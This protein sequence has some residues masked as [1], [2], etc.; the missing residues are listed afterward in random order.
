MSQK[1]LIYSCIFGSRDFIDVF[2][3]LLESMD[4]YGEVTDDVEYMI[5]THPDLE[6]DV[7]VCLKGYNR[8]KHTIKTVDIQHEKDATCCRFK[9][10]DLIKPDEFQ[11]ILYI[12]IDVLITNKLDNILSIDTQNKLCALREGPHRKRHALLFDDVT[13]EELKD[14]RGTFNAGVLLFEPCTKIRK[15]FDSTVDLLNK[16]FTQSGINQSLYSL[17]EDPPAPTHEMVGDF[18]KYHDDGVMF[19]EVNDQNYLNYTAIKTNMY[20]HKLW[21]TVVLNPKTHK[22]FKGHVISHFAGNYG[23]AEKKE[24]K[25]KEYLEFLKNEN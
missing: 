4:M 18:V 21:T 6:D 10:F 22:D 11:K 14:T 2:D 7:H 3:L 17:H 20:E 15:L 23:I 5:I 13:F 9:I 19:K 16:T 24:I 25:M 12:D 1:H 8:I